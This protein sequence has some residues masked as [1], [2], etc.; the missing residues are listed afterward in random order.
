MALFLNLA[1][2]KNHIGSTPAS[3]KPT[4]RKTLLV[5]FKT[6]RSRIILA[7]ILPAIETEER[8][9]DDCCD[10]HGHPFSYKGEYTML[11]H[12]LDVQWSLG[13]YTKRKML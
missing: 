13:T 10:Q 12:I 3:T 7:M 6:R 2:R 11:S 8:F 9:R 5:M 4:L 1:G